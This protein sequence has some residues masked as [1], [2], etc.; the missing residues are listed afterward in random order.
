MK[1]VVISDT[2]IPTRAK[3]LPE[4]VL[5][6]IRNSDGIIH[7][8][9]FTSIDFYRQLREIK[10]LLYAVKGNMDDDEIYH[11]LPEVL[12]FEVEGVKMGLYH[13]IGAPWGL[14][15]KVLE[16]FKDSKDIKLIIF[17]HSHKPLKRE[18]GGITLFNPGSPTDT[19]FAPKKSFG[20][21]EVQEGKILRVEHVLI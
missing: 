14:E 21:L 17:G 16:K 3:N 1:F 13:G 19:I 2:H 18:E 11:F 10:S 4:I 5:E 7:A 9:D 6:E 12:V 20:I 8:G 15:K